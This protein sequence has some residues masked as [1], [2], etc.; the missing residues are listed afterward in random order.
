VK[1]SD[2]TFKILISPTPLVGPDR[3]GKGDNHANKAFAYEGKQLRSFIGAQ[4]NMFVCCGDRHW[5]YVSVAADSGVREYSCG[6][7]SDKHAG[8]WSNDKRTPM[9]QYLNVTGGFLSVTI[10]ADPAGKPL[11]VF[12]HFSTRGKL[13]NED[14]Q[15]ARP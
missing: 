3:N 13:L 14:I 15:K 12:R 5:Q 2:A 4:K 8:G 11:A 10:S 9:H 7:T 1:A 6:P